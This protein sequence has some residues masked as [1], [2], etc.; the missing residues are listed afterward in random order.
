[1]KSQLTRLQATYTIAGTM[2]G[3]GILALPSSMA[4]SGFL[5]GMIAI[6]VIGLLSILTALYIV[7]ASFRTKEVLHMPALVE[8]YLGKA[9]MTVVFLGILVYVYGALAGYISAGGNL[10]HEISSGVI[11]FWLGTI[12]YF[13][14]SSLVVVFG[15]KI[16]GFVELIFFTLMIVFVV[17]ISAIALPHA[18]SALLA[19]YQWDTMPSIFGVVLFAYAG[20]IIIPTVAR[21]MQ[22][23]RKGLIISTILGLLGPMLIYLI[24]S[25]VFTLVIPRGIPAEVIDYSETVTLYQA[26]YHG[27]PATI[28]LG[29]LIGGTVVLIGSMFA[30]LSTFTS[31]LGF[32]LSMTDCWID[33]AR[34]LRLRMNRVA[35]I[36]LTIC[37][38]LF[39]ALTNPTS[40]LTGI[41]IAGMYGGSLFAGIIPP[42][43]VL[44]ARKRGEVDS[45]FRVPGGSILPILVMLFFCLGVI[46]KTVQ[47]LQP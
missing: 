5:P 7:E 8:L 22:H 37:I 26:R 21:G 9:G 43:L 19:D 20:H 25:L 15:L 42:L 12:L 13:T 41:D 28:P 47:L 23:D 17:I 46:Y 24:W 30:I 10:I 2:I 29:H 35:A 31:Y 27:Q 4:I 18:D 1:M 3:A 36:L 6:I 32:S 44:S 45:S 39:M 40:F 34:N 11:P 38:P 33:G 14:V 16:T